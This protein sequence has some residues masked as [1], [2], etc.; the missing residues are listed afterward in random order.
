[1][2]RAGIMS[3][4]RA[5]RTEF[6]M[7]E[8]PALRIGNQSALSAPTLLRPFE[9]AVENGFDAFEWFP[10]RNSSGAGWDESSLDRDAREYIKRTARA[11]DIR[12]SVHAPWAANPL[13]PKAQPI[14][15]RQIDLA[16]DIG[17]AILNIHLYTENGMDAYARAIAPILK[18]LSESDIKL[19]VENTPL[20]PPGHFN[21]LFGRIRESQ[22]E[23]MGAVGM[24]LDIGHANL[25]QATR[26]D[27]LR[28]FDMLD[29]ET[30]IIHLH[31][32]ENWGDRD[33]HLTLFTGPAGRDASGIDALLRRLWERRYLGSAILEQ[34]PEP[35]SLLNLARDKLKQTLQRISIPFEPARPREAG[36]PESREDEDRFIDRL[37]NANR[38]YLSWREKLEFVRSLFA[39]PWPQLSIEQLVLLAIYLRFLGTGEVATAEDGRHFRPSHT[40]RASS[41]I[42]DQLAKITDS[43]G[44]FVARKIFP[45]LPSSNPAFMRAEPLTRIRDIAHRNDIP[46]DLKREIKNTLQNKLHRCAGPEDLVTSTAIR[47]RITAPGAQYSADFVNEFKIFH[48]E[49]KEFFNARSLEEQLISISKESGPDVGLIRDFLEARGRIDEGIAQ[50]RAALQL[51]T[52]LRRSLLARV[53]QNPG[54]ESQDLRLAEIALESFAFV[55]LSRMI[56]AFENLGVEARWDVLLDTLRLTV[57]NVSLSGFSTGECRAIGA[58]LDAWRRVFVPSQ[59]EQL[60]RLKATV[61]RGRRLAEEYSDRVSALFAG[62]VEKLGRALGVADSGIKVFVEGEIRGHVVFQLSKLASLLLA[63]IRSLAGLPGIDILVPGRAAGQLLLA[64]SLD[65]VRDSPHRRVLAVLKAAQGDEEIPGNVAGLILAHEIPHLSHLGIRARQGNI[66]L[67]SCDDP[68]E[69]SRFERLNGQWAVLDAGPGGVNLEIA[70][71]SAGRDGLPSLGPVHPAGPLSLPEVSLQPE[72]RCLTLDRVVPE[73][74]GG[75]AAAARRLE[76]LSRDPQ[77]GFRTPPGLVV[78]FGVMEECLRS[79]PE[80]NAEYIALM[81]RV[82]SLPGDG[83]D[84]SVERLR[85]LVEQLQ[86]PADIAEI[87]ER[88]FSAKPDAR[89]PRLM[90][91]SSANAEDLPQLAGAGLYDSIANVAPPGVAIAVRRVW[92]SLWT[93]RAALSRKQSGIR[94]EKAHMAVLL[95]EMVVPEYSFILHSVNPINGDQGEVYVELALGL[96]ETL[97][98]ASAPGSPYRMVCPKGPGETRMLAFANISYALLPDSGGGVTRNPVEYSKV[99]LSQDWMFAQKLGGRLAAIAR[100]LEGALTR[101]QDVEGA[102]VGEEIYIVQSRPQQGLA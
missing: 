55:L 17:A 56:N 94:H 79:M 68:G 26:N 57:E 101:A 59:R 82:D 18:R 24:C 88:K 93:R 71:N 84:A 70:S 53:G 20:T 92:A 67:V 74:G 81:S 27:Y 62:R 91:R 52:G 28:Y 41:D 37:A 15:L 8:T 100:F 34:W 31:L 36:L 5:P 78:P 64:D 13:N 25:C 96:G 45:W 69:F 9:Y 66:V 75:K 10:D 29:S 32:H 35:A 42:Q 40:A 87:S 89:P 48:E 39:D 38:Q 6:K 63:K 12:L 80:V 47:E 73:N 72:A 60:L 54:S 21:E 14:L 90:V 11:H 22:I 50:Q 1:M 3:S 97:A 19:A 76:E 83:F 30:P 65:A 102:I 43:T 51:L 58:E 16:A 7:P 46:Q 49:L 44:A 23:G 33:S 95:Q 4:R 99:S 86:P 77:A 98:S 61:D 85:T 2:R